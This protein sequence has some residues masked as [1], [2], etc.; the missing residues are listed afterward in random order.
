VPAEPPA[1]LPNRIN[2][3]TVAFMTG[4]LRGAAPEAMQ[5]LLLSEIEHWAELI[6]S[7]SEYA[8]SPQRSEGRL[9]KRSTE[10]NSRPAGRE[11]GDRP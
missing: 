6:K 10:V 2:V 1:V 4:R 7:M 3:D 5:K 11:H 9:T 8:H